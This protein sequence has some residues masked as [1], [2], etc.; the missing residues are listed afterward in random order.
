MKKNI[1]LFVITL[2]MAL[3]NSSCAQKKA[4]DD[5]DEIK[6]KPAYVIEKNMTAQ[7]HG[8]EESIDDMVVKAGRLCVI[9][10]N[11]GEQTCSFQLIDCSESFFVSNDKVIYYEPS[12]DDA[13]ERYIERSVF[14]SST[15]KVNVYEAAPKSWKK[16]ADVTLVPQMY[17]NSYYTKAVVKP[18]VIKDKNAVYVETRGWGDSFEETRTSMYNETVYRITLYDKQ[19]EELLCSYVYRGA[20]LMKYNLDSKGEY[21]EDFASDLK[22]SDKGFCSANGSGDG[23]EYRPCSELSEVVGEY[24]SIGLVGWIS[25]TQMV[26]D[27]I[28]YKVK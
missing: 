15:K 9:E 22:V 4:A 21:L 20:Q 13:P 2:L 28:V 8:S 18:I 24:P 27:D 26:I 12:Q 19:G 23:A 5:F 16:G 3:P 17:S 1:Y 10:E 6:S 14:N 7:N 11:N 25:A